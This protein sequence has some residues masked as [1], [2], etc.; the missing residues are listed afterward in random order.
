[1]ALLATP[2]I[3][4]AAP[5]ASAARLSLDAASPQVRQGARIGA[6]RK[7]ENKA[8]SGVVLAVLAVAAVGAGIAVA[9]SGGNDDAA[10]ASP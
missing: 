7:A 9:V 4:S 2:V 10:P 3:A 8:S 6:E 1:L 5:A